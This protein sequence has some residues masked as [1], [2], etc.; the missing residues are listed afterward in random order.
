MNSSRS[1]GQ[2]ASDSYIARDRGPVLAD[3]S[4]AR[5]DGAIHA[6]AL[7]I[8]AMPLAPAVALG[9]STARP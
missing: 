4:R 8:G 9:A 2:V 3:E 5:R 6:D 1:S 7:L